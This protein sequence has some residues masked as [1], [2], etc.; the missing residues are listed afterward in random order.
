MAVDLIALVL[1]DGLSGLL[2]MRGIVVREER[3]RLET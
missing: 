2:S 3:P 1:R